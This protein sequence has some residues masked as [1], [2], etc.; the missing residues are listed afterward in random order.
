MRLRY[1]YWAKI[2]A[3]VA[4]FFYEELFSPLV[5]LI[6]ANSPLPVEVDNAPGAVPHLLAALRSGRVQYDDG[7][8]TGKF[9]AA[10]SSDLGRLGAKF[11]SRD[12]SYRLAEAELPVPVI[13][14]A[15]AYHLRAKLAHDAIKAELER[16]AARVDA[17]AYHVSATGMV[18]AVDADWRR[19]AA[20][21]ALQP[22]LSEA[23]VEALA[24]EYTVALNLPIRR[25]MLEETVKLRAEVEANARQGYRFDRLIDTIKTRAGISRRKAK[26][27]ARQE[28]ALFMAKFQAKRFHDAGVVKYQW[29][30][31][32]DDRV[33]PATWLTPAERKHAGNHRAL[34]KGIYR[35]DA[36]PDAK[37]FSIGKPCNPGEDYGCRCVPIPLATA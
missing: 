28:T 27:L 37:F 36:P 10:I 13:E 34:D 15:R 25:W 12:G 3:Q 31:S 18:E 6:E 14:A 20:K 21:L 8:F 16:A 30:T 33:R 26:F 4:T 23:A 11:D 19:S 24:R 5:K 29:S 1:A 9:S 2:E 17:S 22:R 32:H 7:K 35:W